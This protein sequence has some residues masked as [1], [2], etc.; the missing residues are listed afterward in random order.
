MANAGSRSSCTP[1]S[2]TRERSVVTQLPNTTGAGISAHS[3][4]AVAPAG[5]IAEPAPPPAWTAALLTMAREIWVLTDRQRVLEALLAKQGLVAGDAIAAWQ[6]D[7]TTQA[8]LD[9]EC[10]AFIDRLLADLNP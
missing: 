1:S 4:P 3:T 10:R 8:E 2:R 9:R 7:A 6:P 5:S